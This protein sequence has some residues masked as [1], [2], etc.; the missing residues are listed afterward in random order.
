MY[1][2]ELIKQLVDVMAQHG[3]LEVEGNFTGSTFPTLFVVDE[4]GMEK[5]DSDFIPYSVWME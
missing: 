1:A 4:N 5:E 2:S 3:D